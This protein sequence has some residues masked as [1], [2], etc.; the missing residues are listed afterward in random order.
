MPTFATP[1]PIAVRIDAI[2]GS[3][4]LVATDRADTVVQVLPRD[5]SR[6]SDVWA[7][8]HTRV[9][10]RD[11]K[12]VV[13]GAK[14]GLAFFRNCA[15]DVEIALPARSRLQASL[16]SADLRAAGE[17]RDVRIAT[18]SGDVQIDAVT[19]NIKATNSSGSFTVHT[20]HG[21][22]WIATASGEVSVGELDGDLKFK[23]AGGSLTVRRLSGHLKAHT[24]SG[25]VEVAAAVRGGVSAHTSSGEVTVGVAEGTAA[26][27]DIVTGSGAVS[28][29][30]QA[31]DGPHQGD[32]TLVLQVRSGSGDVSVRRAN[33]ARE[34]V[35]AT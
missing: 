12:L 25:S 6:D 9:D 10:F 31:S 30:L 20:V 5:F 21:N 11:G 1:E 19:G 7:S 2:E 32:E 34:T 17:F 8:E 13:S 14:R 22:A 33:P 29:D 27:L 28:N 23:A 24:A 3:I 26:R 15:T 35:P 18:A 4:R 16:G